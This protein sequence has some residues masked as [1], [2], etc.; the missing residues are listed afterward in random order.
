MKLQGTVNEGNY[1]FVEIPKAKICRTYDKKKA[2]YGAFRESEDGKWLYFEIAEIENFNK[3][4]PNFVTCKAT[5][6][7]AERIKKLATPRDE[8]QPPFKIGATLSLRA[9]KCYENMR[10]QADTARMVYNVEHFFLEGGK[11]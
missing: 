8:K 10:N 3:A 9:V 2:A 4:G 11:V 6:V 5:G 7:T 1:G